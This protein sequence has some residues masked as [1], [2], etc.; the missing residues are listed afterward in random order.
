MSAPDDAGEVV[1]R[2]RGGLGL[3]RDDER[4]ARLVDEDRVDLV[5]DRVRMAALDG[6]LERRG[7]VVA[8]VVEA[9]LRVR[10]VDDVG[11]V[12]LLALLEGHH[13]AD[14]AGPHAELLVDGPHPLGVALGEVVVDRDEVDA[15]GAE[16]IQ[17]ERHC[18]DEGLS[19]AGLHL[20]DVALVED[21]RAHQLDV[22]GAQADRA[23]GG[24]PD[25]RE[26]LEDEL[27]EVLPVLEPLPE[28]GG[29][30][31]ELLVGQRLEVRFER[32][33]VRG[34]VGQLL[35]APALAH[36]KDAL[37]CTV[38]LGHQLVRVPKVTVGRS[39]SP[40]GGRRAASRVARRRRTALLP[41]ARWARYLPGWVSRRSPAPALL[42]PSR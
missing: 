19:F 37:Q 35:E 40:R 33:D 15:V 29:L 7:H 12:G 1:V 23:L 10:P 20:G 11:L 32:G 31:R 6:A 25:G 17:V 26:G 27:V 16:R 21:H 22:E 9:E 4:R 24:F 18:R 13:V 34:L 5:H 3:A 14:V 39:R 36:A 38:V 28:L 41:R 42:L 8:E 30:R 2:L